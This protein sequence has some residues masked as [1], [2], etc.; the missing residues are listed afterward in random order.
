MT[1]QI[2][3]L[4]GIVGVA[5]TLSFT[6]NSIAQQ[7][8]QDCV[9][10]STIGYLAINLETFD[11][12]KT[13]DLLKE[14]TG[15]S[16]MTRRI[17]MGQ[18][19]AG[20][21][22]KTIKDAG[23]KAVYVHLS[24]SDIPVNG[25]FGWIAVGQDTDVDQAANTLKNTFSVFGLQVVAADQGVLI[26]QSGTIA[27]LKDN[28]LPQRADFEQYLPAGLP[29]EELSI[30]L[31]PSQDQ[32]RVLTE[33]MGPFPNPFDKFD[34]KLLANGASRVVL[35][36]KCSD[37]DQRL[38]LRYSGTDS[39]ACQ[40]IH[41]Q[42]MQLAGEFSDPEKLAA[43]MPNKPKAM[44]LIL[45]GIL[46]G[47][48]IAGQAIDNNVYRYY[49]SSR[50]GSLAKLIETVGPTFNIAE[51]AAMESALL[52]H[53]RN[54][55]LA[56]HNYHDA[57]KSLPASAIVDAEDRPLLSW[58][59]AILPFLGHNNLYQKFKLGEPW[60]SEHNIQ[61]L[62]E[63]PLEMQTDAVL[64]QQGLTSFMM[65]VGDGAIGRIANPLNLTDIS[66]GSSRTILLVQAAKDRAVPWTKPQDWQLDV[67]TP[68]AGL[69]E[70]GEAGFN[71][72]FAD[73]SVRVLS[74]KIDIAHLKSLFTAAANDYV[75]P[76]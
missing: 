71:V 3:F 73:G 56:M 35:S 12:E 21:F 63:I 39:N 38:E 1:K 64:A 53:L 42:L 52:D 48:P 76:R 2:H 6:T 57:Y 9:D 47:L 7:S 72:C 28:V 33:L 37:D 40:T 74:E 68:L 10:S 46:K 11:I 22:L 25:P 69:V 66:D 26:G 62:K 61:L 19:V 49:F 54:V 44:Q 14:F 43:A 4:V 60:D 29:S 20:T 55:C 16:N 51:R 32:L 18:Q 50:S 5:L 65:V 75:E 67:E 59:V 27:R 45:S 13:A 23:G 31:A 34:G 24:L 15:D 8:H 70:P 41:L 36:T 30:V 17:E 58:R